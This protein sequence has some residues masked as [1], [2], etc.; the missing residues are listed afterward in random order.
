[1]IVDV[2]GVD[3]EYQI[4]NVLEFNSTRK[5]MSVVVR[6]PDGKIKLYCKGADA[7]I[8]P[9]LVA[10]CKYV[11]ETM[12]HLEV[13]ATEGLRTLCCAVAEIPEQE[14]KSWNVL[15][16]QA[17]ISIVNREKEVLLFQEQY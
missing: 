6:T 12:E 10:N 3:E 2:G 15:F 16:N 13:L 8:Y 14:Y 7:V 17:S 5:R 9:R 4:L 11:K 1:V